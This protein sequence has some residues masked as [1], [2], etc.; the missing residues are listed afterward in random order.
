[1]HYY[2]F[3]I[4]DYASH[5]R[6]LTLLEDLAYRRL[7]DLY[8]L[9]EQPLNPSS[10]IVARLINMRD[11]E[12]EIELVLNEFFELVDGVG[13][14][15]QRADEEISA[16]RNRREAASRAGKASAERRMNERS[17][18]VQL[19]KKHKPV[20]INQEPKNKSLGET[21]K[22]T[23]LTGSFTPKDQHA[24]LAKQ[25]KL[26]LNDEFA[27]FA[28]YYTAKGST[29]KDW[30]AALRNWLRKS[31]DYKVDKPAPKRTGYVHDLSQMDYT[32][33]VDED[34]NF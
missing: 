16:Y 28:D 5:T 9:H 3:N 2:Q 4:G 8:Y 31:G 26:N 6:H 11:N 15:N 12:R 10:T 24:E 1:M 17:T 33:G 29:M 14:V 22:A 32:K 23:A 25:L 30:D 7:L 27:R 34:G 21:K 19:N 18:P 20:T 13:W